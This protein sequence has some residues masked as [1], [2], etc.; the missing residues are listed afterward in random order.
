MEMKDYFWV[1]GAAIYVL[2]MFPLFYV[3]Q[4]Q[5]DATYGLIDYIAT[6][7]AFL[8]MGQAFVTF[9]PTKKQEMKPQTQSGVPSK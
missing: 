4:F 8:V 1:I 2:G 9:W 3:Y 7:G 6:F 5:G